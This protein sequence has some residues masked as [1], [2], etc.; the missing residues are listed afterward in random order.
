MVFNSK[1]LMLNSLFDIVDNTN[2]DVKRIQYFF[3]E[4]III[5]VI[6]FDVVEML[7][8]LGRSQTRSVL[9]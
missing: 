2:V 4:Q 7:M 3:K 8:D 5:V 6:D 1:L 9:V